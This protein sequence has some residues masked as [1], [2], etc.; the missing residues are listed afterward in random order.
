MALAIGSQ[1]VNVLASAADDSRHP[2][3]AVSVLAECRSFVRLPDG[4]SGAQPGAHD[5]LVMAMAIGLMVRA[6]LAERG[7]GHLG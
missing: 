6:E 1:H 4:S 5:D 3:P 7:R 2:G